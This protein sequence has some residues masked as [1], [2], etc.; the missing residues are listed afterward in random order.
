MKSIVLLFCLSLF[1]NSVL[2]QDDTDID[3]RWEDAQKRLN[4]AA[5]EIADLSSM[6]INGLFT[7]A[8]ERRAM[9]GVNIDTEKNSDDEGVRVLGVSP[10]GP[11]EEAGIKS[12]DVLLSI[13]HNKL[14]GDDDE[15]SAAK[16]L[17]FMS[18]VQ[19]GDEVEVEYLRGK[20]IRTAK[21]EAEP[22][23]ASV[24]SF[25]GKGGPNGFSFSNGGDFE[26]LMPDNFREFS[27]GQWGDLRLVA[28]SEDLGEY[29]GVDEGL[30]VVRAPDDDTLKLRD[31]DVILSIDSREPEDPRHAMRILRSY[32]A[33]EKVQIQI[34][35]KKKKQE[36]DLELPQRSASTGKR[37]FL[38]SREE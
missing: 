34:V 27:L 17:S 16:L 30:L 37:K 35:R 36:L 21:I 19:P 22:V 8:G 20:Q 9:L 38:F 18:D 32:R 14:L 29:F 4:N 12:G 7:G 1:T 6:N 11:A 24:F 13:N 10:G 31:G 15:S 33:G 26:F 23:R 25:S 5:K 2:A 28:L 3:A